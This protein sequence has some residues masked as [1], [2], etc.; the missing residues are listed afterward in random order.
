MPPS[1]NCSAFTSKRRQCHAI[2]GKL[3]EDCLTQE[4]QEK[5][6][7]SFQHCRRQAQAYYGTLEGIH[8]KGV[9]ASWA[10]SFCFA[11]PEFGMDDEPSAA[12]TKKH[13]EEA[14]EYVNGNKDIKAECRRVAMDLS[15]CMSK[16][17]Y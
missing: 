2:Y 10:E 12:L 17:N 11:R 8:H 6:C 3:G 13:H 5:R 9:C 7:V 1:I 16:M 14:R 4:L 15:K